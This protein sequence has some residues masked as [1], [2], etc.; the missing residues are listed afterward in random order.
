GKRITR[1][2][3]A[4]RFNQLLRACADDELGIDRFRGL[5]RRQVSY[6]GTRFES[7]AV[8][9]AHEQFAVS[10]EHRR[11]DGTIG[12]RRSGEEGDRRH[13]DKLRGPAEGQAGRG[14]EA[15]ANSGE[16]SWPDA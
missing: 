14:S 11:G 4:A 3:P 7:P 8:E 10:P 6:L 12:R 13:A 16:A 5:V 15:D 2:A 1:F 9:L